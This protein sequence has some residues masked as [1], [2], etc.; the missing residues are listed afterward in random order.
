ML[1][2]AECLVFLERSLP[3]MLASLPPEEAQSLLKRELSRLSQRGMSEAL[4]MKWA[5]AR[6]APFARF[7]PPAFAS[8]P[9]PPRWPLPIQTF[10]NL[11]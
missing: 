8:P 1:A 5:R 2:D 3:P 4:A 7:S 11:V 10:Y 9:Q 6:L